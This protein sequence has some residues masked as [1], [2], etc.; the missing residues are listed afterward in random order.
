MD[1]LKVQ[2]FN[3]TLQIAKC[4]KCITS[5]TIGLK[6]EF[7]FDSQ[8]DTLTKMAVFQVGTMAKSV[9]VKGNE[10][11]IPWEVLEKPNA[12]LYIGVYGVNAD[13]TIA[14]P[15]VWAEVCVIASGADPEVDPSVDP[16]LPVWQELKN[17]VEGLKEGINDAVTQD[18][19]QEALDNLEIP[20]GGDSPDLNDISLWEQGGIN[21]TGSNMDSE[22]YIRT[23]DYIPEDVE[24]VYAEKGCAFRVAVYD[25]ANAFI[26]FWNGKRITETYDFVYYLNPKGLQ[27]YKIRLLCRHLG[28]TT[29]VEDCCNIHF[30]KGIYKDTF[31]GKPTLTF[32]DDDGVLEALKNWEAISDETGVNITS[33]L[34]TNAMGDDADSQRTKASWNDVERFQNRGF[35][36]VSHTH[37]HISVKRNTD[38]VVKTDFVN[39]IK[40][41]REHG[42]ESRYLVYPYNDI[43]SAKIKLVK[44]Y[45]MAGVGLGGNDA[46]PGA[47]NTLPIYTHWLR[48]YS[49]NDTS[50]K[51]VVERSVDLASRFEIGNIT[52]SK[53]TDTEPKYPGNIHVAIRTKEGYFYSA[54]AGTTFTLTDYTDV[55]LGVYY[56][57]D[58]G[59]TWTSLVRQTSASTSPVTMYQNARV[60]LKIQ[61]LTNT[62]QTDTTLA[63]RLVVTPPSGKEVKEFWNAHPF[64]DITTLK[65]YIDEAIANNGWVIIMS[66]LRNDADPDLPVYHDADS[67]NM[68]VELCKY[69]TEKGVAIQTFGEAF[70]KYKNIMEIG[71]I[72]TTQHYVV[73]C[74]GVVH[75]KE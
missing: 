14:I 37:G 68:I 47:T 41:L 60:V 29:G 59:A 72:Y 12:R 75:Y 8:W 36:F 33:A 17:D 67:H 6:A 46:D 57:Y 44:Q 9:E 10:A 22:D 35:E 51:V 43:D 7:T 16:T 27:E 55:A 13:C 61:S 70:Q 19:L 2:V 26:G 52:F 53:N 50:Q 21:Q 5:G 65:S 45:F 54:P 3:N 32:I 73:D 31:C 63:S 69:A 48:R 66:H 28:N 23:K 15:T 64:R 58:D 11:V 4:P 20:D 39:T 71:T 56:S 1:G 49:I 34:V 30:L 74:N 25:A 62:K 24:L 38:A 18:E 40:A 42:C